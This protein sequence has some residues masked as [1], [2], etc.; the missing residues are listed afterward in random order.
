MQSRLNVLSDMDGTLT[1]SEDVLHKAWV[2]LAHDRGHDFKVFDYG[3]VF[4]RR[5]LEVCEMV[6]NH[7]GWNDAPADLHK[8]YVA[9][10]DRLSKTELT[11]RPGTRKALDDLNRAGAVMAL[12]TSGSPDH[13]AMTDRRLGIL[14]Y[15]KAIVNSNTPGL[16]RFKPFPDPYILGARKINAQPEECI[17][18]EDSPNGIRSGKAAECRAVIGLTHAHSPRQGLIDAGADI[19]FDDIAEA[20][21]YIISLAA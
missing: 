20:V 21:P 3:S 2:L 14:R 5:D 4:G 18:L 7:Y 10:V 17:V 6:A 19:V 9:R 13:V 15:F 1:L 16:K 12:V 11:L 8:E